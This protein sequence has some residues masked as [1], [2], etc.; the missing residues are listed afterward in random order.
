MLGIPNTK[1]A[2]IK[3]KYSKTAY[4]QKPSV[5]SNPVKK[6]NN[7][8][9]QRLCRVPRSLKDQTPAAYGLAYEEV[10]FASA[11][12]I[13]L[14]GWFVPAPESNITVIVAHGYRSNKSGNLAFAG[15]LQ[16]AG[17]N[18]FLPDF[19]G[20]GQS[21]DGKGTSIGIMERLD[22]H[23]AVAYLQARGQE[24]IA[25]LGTSMG[26]AA[27]ILAAAENPAIKAVIADSAYAQLYRSIHTQVAVTWKIPRLVAWPVAHYLYRVIAHHHGF[28]ARALHPVNAVGKLA[29]GSLL[30]LHG[31]ADSLTEVVN[32][33][34]LQARAQ[35]PCELWTLPGVEH[36]KLFK[37]RP[38][39]YKSRVLAFLST[40]KWSGAAAT[41]PAEP[42]PVVPK[43]LKNITYKKEL[44]AA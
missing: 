39:E 7:Y 1:L 31:E 17:Y 21:D 18:V 8:A 44:L 32:S 38:D 9:I 15:W 6:F 14:K 3:N 34:M 37:A 10:S 25:V 26:A 28:D 43:L 30:L 20:H 19:R 5:T 24:N 23:G 4:Q 33:Q 42:D 13:Q 41:L 22:L 35:Q 36:T 12:Q 2:Y 29:A 11:D 27:A 40:V 16:Q